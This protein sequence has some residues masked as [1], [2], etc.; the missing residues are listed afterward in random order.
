MFDL[1]KEVSMIKLQGLVWMV[2][3][4]LLSSCTKPSQSSQHDLARKGKSI[5][6]TTCIACHN[7]DPKKN[8]PMGPSSW[9]ASLELLKKRIKEAGYPEG[10]APKQQTKLMQP[11]P[12]IS[13][14]DIEAIHAYLNER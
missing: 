11:L 13:D 1:V 12:K 5:Y 9:G 3:M 7:T 4:V 10:Y 6:Q 2:G 8:G 14:Q